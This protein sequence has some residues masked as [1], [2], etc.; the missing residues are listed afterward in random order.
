MDERQ[1][2]VAR[3]SGESFA[4]RRGTCG[5]DPQTGQC[6]VIVREEWPASWTEPATIQFLEDGTDSLGVGT[7]GLA[8]FYL[9]AVDSTNCPPLTYEFEVGDIVRVDETGQALPPG[10]RLRQPDEGEPSG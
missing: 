3:V 7:D 6:R 5:G 8:N 2:A 9:C 10:A 1:Q 4:E